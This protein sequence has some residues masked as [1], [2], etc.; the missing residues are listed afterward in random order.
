MPTE[1]MES[2][3]LSSEDEIPSAKHGPIIRPDQEDVVAQRE[4]WNRFAIGFLLDYP[5]VL[6]KFPS[7]Y[8]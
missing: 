5:K 7:K 4:F 3:L 1:E 6:D 8:Y 2:D